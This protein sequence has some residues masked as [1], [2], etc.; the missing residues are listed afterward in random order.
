MLYPFMTLADE[1][2]I[3]HSDSYI[4]DGKEH[5]RVEIEK[6]IEGGFQS[7]TCILPEYAWQDVQGFSDLEI[8]KLQ[9]LLASLAHVIF[10][11]ARTGGFDNASGF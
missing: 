9:D 4:E 2:E 3:V 1:T 11:L 7:A 10:R 6:P 5:V 8:R